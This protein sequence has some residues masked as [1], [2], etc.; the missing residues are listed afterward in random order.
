[1]IDTYTINKK[2]EISDESL[3]KH[4]VDDGFTTRDIVRIYSKAKSNASKFKKR[5]WKRSLELGLFE[6]LNKNQKD[7][8]K[9][10]AKSK[11]HKIDIS[12]LSKLINDG[13]T[14]GRIIDEMKVRSRDPHKLV[15]TTS[16]KLGL[17]DRLRWNNRSYK[18]P[19]WNPYVI[20]EKFGDVIMET[21]RSGGTFKE[22]INNTELP[23]NAIRKYFK[24]NKKLDAD[25][26]INSKLNAKKLATHASHI[27][28]D[29]YKGKLNKPI[30]TDISDVFINM[31]N[32]GCY[33][34]DIKRKLKSEFDYGYTKYNELC[35]IFGKP[36]KNPQTGK[37][38]PMY[39]KSPSRKSGIGV[40]CH[41]I[42]DNKK[43]ICRSSLELKIYTYLYQNDIKF[44]ISSH[45]IKY[46]FDGINRTY[47]PD[48][49]INNE[50]FEIKP[51]KLVSQKI[52]VAKHVALKLYCDKFNLRF[53]YITEET[54]DLSFFDVN[55][56][57]EM[58]KDGKLIIDD[59]NLNKLKKYL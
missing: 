17:D 50:I 33:G 3:I 36:T 55:K 43:I 13:L 24:F 48:I 40:K 42:I 39:G 22:I 52:N 31:K 49:V 11:S 15:K 12:H 46:T 35:K 34:A 32:S 5:I 28:R 58:I 51:L 44:S 14:T 37:D 27:R 57:D 41:L 38:N 1:M 8:L 18:N 19:D 6:R 56:V 23:L 45:R 47:N 16:M 30:T 4:I 59:K 21:L 54:Y 2:I 29:K 53:G 26:K 9:L 10:Y 20:E 7:K 25:R